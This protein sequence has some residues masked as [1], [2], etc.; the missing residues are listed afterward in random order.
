MCKTNIL[1]AVYIFP[2]D[3]VKLVVE[4]MRVTFIRIPVLYCHCCFEQR[5]FMIP[6]S[7]KVLGQN[8]HQYECFH[9]DKQKRKKKISRAQMEE[10]ENNRRKAPGKRF[11][12]SFLYCKCQRQVDALKG[13]PVTFFFPTFAIPPS[14]RIFQSNTSIRRRRRGPYRW[15]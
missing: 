4:I 1:C 9:D 7:Q 6:I 8:F 11:A 10:H 14:K 15:W 5:L 13:H 3:Y 12:N 2:N